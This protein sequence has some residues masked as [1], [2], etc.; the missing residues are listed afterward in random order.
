MRA[1]SDRIGRGLE[2]RWSQEEAA[3]VLTPFHAIGKSFAP[4][5]PPLSCENV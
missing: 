2:R 4:C 5:L 1:S 3:L